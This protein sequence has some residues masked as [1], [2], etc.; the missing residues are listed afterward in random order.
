[1]D[2]LGASVGPVAHETGG[3]FL[4]LKL[5]PLYPVILI[6]AIPS[7]FVQFGLALTGWLGLGWGY[8]VGVGV[9][10]VHTLGYSWAGFEIVII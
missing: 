1:M 3:S 6:Q 10:I 4:S 8:M 9:Y 7:A 5:C 2:V